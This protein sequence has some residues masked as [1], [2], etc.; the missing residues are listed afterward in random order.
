MSSFS[1]TQQKC[2]ACDKTVHFAEMMSADGVPYH[3]TCFRCTHCNGRLTMSN[4]SKSPLDGSLYCKPHFEQLLRENGGFANKLATSGK[5]NGLS[6]APSKVST[7]FSGTQEKCN[8]CK[9]T[10]Y[11][12][13]KVTVE[14]EFYHKSCFRC[15]HGGCFLNPSSYA[16]LDGILYCKPHFSQLFKQKGCYNHLTKTTSL[17]KSGSEE[18][19]ALAKEQESS[20]EPKEEEAENAQ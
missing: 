6:R 9:K 16:A 13:E 3:N 2:K 1:G 7:L 5:P 12:L 20:A 10:V 14:G 18:G 19:A 11:P 15:A 17:K 4:Y 8:V